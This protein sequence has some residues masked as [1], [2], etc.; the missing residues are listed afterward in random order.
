MM[1]IALGVLVLV[2]GAVLF[3]ATWGATLAYALWRDKERERLYPDY[4]RY[5]SPFPWHYDEVN[6]EEGAA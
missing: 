3:V 4:G 1:L 2:T 5:R 6:R